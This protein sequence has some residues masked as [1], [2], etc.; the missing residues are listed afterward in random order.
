MSDDEILPNYLDEELAHYAGGGDG[1]DHDTVNELAKLVILGRGRI[2]ELE[3]E[4][5]VLREALALAHRKGALD[6]NEEGWRAWYSAVALCRKR[7]QP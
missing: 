7:G 6:F 1:W 4:N 2:A 3:A 5:A